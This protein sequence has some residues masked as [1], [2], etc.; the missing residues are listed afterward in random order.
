MNNIESIRFSIVMSGI[1]LCHS[2]AYNVSFINWF[3]WQTE[4]WGN[5]VPWIIMIAV[6]EYTFVALKWIELF[7]KLRLQWLIYFWPVKVMNNVFGLL[8]RFPGKK[9]SWPFMYSA[10][11]IFLGRSTLKA[12]A[13]RNICFKWSWFNLNLLYAI[14]IICI[15]NADY[16]QHQN[17]TILWALREV[18]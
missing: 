13:W 3:S 10:S 4:I 5:D 18:K 11:F 14:I 17:Y 8:L 6:P 1:K 16:T 12:E 7:L 9:G 15:L 2:C